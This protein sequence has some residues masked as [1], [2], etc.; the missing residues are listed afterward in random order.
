MRTM[1]VTLSLEA[2]RAVSCAELADELW[3][4][5]E[6][7]NISNA[8]QAHATRVRKV[9]EAPGRSGTSLVCSVAG[10]YRLDV[11]PNCID[12]HRFLRL[13]SDGSAALAGDPG[14]ALRVLE[15]ALALWRGPALLDAGAGLRCRSAATLFEERRTTVWEMLVIARLIL[16]DESRAV[17]ELGQLVAQNPLSERFCELLMLALYRAGRQSDAL[18]LFRVMQRRLD[19][20]L[21]VRPGGALQRRH[22]EI[23]AQDPALARHDVLWRATRNPGRDGLLAV[24]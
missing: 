18:Q 3:A 5:Q 13:A 19:E 21:G 20:E 14:R 24:R 8:L 15:A 6:I 2:G 9:L 23:L 4:G 10:G 17:A 22:S 11:S 12:A 1:L 16:G 7:G